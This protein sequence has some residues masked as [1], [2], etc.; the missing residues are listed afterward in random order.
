[1]NPFN[2]TGGEAVFATSVVCLTV[3]LCVFV[4]GAVTAK[5]GERICEAVEKVAGAVA[6]AIQGEKK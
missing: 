6:L 2:L 3:T 1:M 5:V 4:S